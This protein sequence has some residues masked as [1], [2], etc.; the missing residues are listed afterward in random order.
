[1]RKQL[2]YCPIPSQC[3]HHNP[4]IPLD[5]WEKKIVL[6]IWSYCRPHKKHYESK[7]YAALLKEMAGYA[8]DCVL[9]AA[10]L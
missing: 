2:L 8:Y 10:V 1:M 9:A 3:V 4:Y 7:S 5:A 6:L